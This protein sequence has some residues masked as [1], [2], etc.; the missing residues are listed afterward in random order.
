MLP[1]PPKFHPRMSHKG[2]ALADLPTGNKS[3]THNTGGWVGQRVNLDETSLPAREDTQVT[4]K[5]IWVHV[6]RGEWRTSLHSGRRLSGRWVFWNFSGETLWRLRGSHCGRAA[7]TLPCGTAT[8]LAQSHTRIFALTAA[9]LKLNAGRVC[10]MLKDS[11]YRF[12]PGL[13]RRR[14]A[15]TAKPLAGVWL[16]H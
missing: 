4:Q 9:V 6:N 12:R 1:Q 3:C 10:V 13:R 11:S 15:R 7:G 14:Y 2:P 16:E 8:G 5:R